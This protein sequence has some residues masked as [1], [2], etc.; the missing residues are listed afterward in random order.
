MTE[1]ESSLNL[2]KLQIL[3]YIEK[4]KKVTDVA[5]ELDMKQPTVTFHMKS[6]EEEMGIA[7]F[8]SKRGRILLTDAGK[9]LY[10]YAV[11]MTGLAAEARKAVQDYA[12]L[13]KGILHIGADSLIGTIHLPRLVNRF[14]RQFPGIQIELTVQPSRTVQELLYNHEVDL[15]FYY[16][17]DVAAAGIKEDLLLEDELVVI[18]APE[19]PFS[20]LK[21]LS[22]QLVAQHFFIQ[23]AEGSFMRDF[24]R[25]YAIESG[26]HLWERMIINSPESVKHTVEDGEFISF[27][28]LS[29]IRSELASGSLQYLAAPGSA[30]KS[31]KAYM[32][33]H[34]DQPYSPLRE[35]F[36][37]FAKQ[38]I[39][40]QDMKP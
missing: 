12:D 39:N 38:H 1:G 14:C 26:I 23:H 10:P 18:F 22:D 11:K 30:G 29:G 25:S 15:A 20:S 13:G 32:A 16:S 9:A 6:L 33:F 37:Q 7:L 5:K 19:H 2:L 17:Q 21:S 8:E 3:V 31:V 27:F 24:T 4:Y 28:P 35:Q 36:K 34:A 40:D